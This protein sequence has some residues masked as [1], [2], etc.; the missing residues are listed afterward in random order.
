MSPPIGEPPSVRYHSVGLREGRLVTRCVYA[1]PGQAEIVEIGR[2][3][4]RC[5]RCG[6]ALKPFRRPKPRRGKP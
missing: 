2:A 4:T 5:P 1:L 6:A 3:R